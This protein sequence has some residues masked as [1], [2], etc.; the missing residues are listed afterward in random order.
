MF[1]R[2]LSRSHQTRSMR[3]RKKHDIPFCQQWNWVLRR[4]QSRAASCGEDFWNQ[5]ATRPWAVNF[6]DNR[7][8]SSRQ[9]DCH[10]WLHQPQRHDL[11]K[12]GQ[13][14]RRWWWVRARSGSGASR[15][16]CVLDHGALIRV[17]LLNE[18][19]LV[20]VVLLVCLVVGGMPQRPRCR[21]P[22]PEE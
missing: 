9:A 15:R 6:P 7:I 2:Q 16:A 18:E 11:L 13:G 12:S 5:F 22:E 4:I 14:G 1:C 8:V 20:C 21:H 10:M 19:A 3:L 17:E